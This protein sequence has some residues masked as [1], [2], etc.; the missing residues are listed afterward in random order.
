MFVDRML[1][2]GSS[3]LLEQWLQFTEARERL[4]ADDVANVS[5]PNY[6]QKDLSL[7][8]FQSAL[9]DRMEQRDNSP[10]DTVSFD[11][12]SMDVQRPR[13]LLF[14]DGND[15]SMEQLMTDE[16][17]NALMHQLAVEL[18]RQQYSTM[19]MALRERVS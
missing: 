18:L 16:A 1:N 17:K 7:V 5:T 14:H 6:K 19:E 11:D 10:P 12:I 2:Q 8:Q 13:N 9:R 3:P 4:L 15:R